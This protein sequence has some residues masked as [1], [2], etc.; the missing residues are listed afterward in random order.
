MCLSPFQSYL[1]FPKRWP[2]HRCCATPACG[3]NLHE[4]L[5]GTCILLLK[6]FTVLCLATRIELY[7]IGGDLSVSSHAA[8]MPPVASERQ[9]VFLQGL[10]LFSAQNQ[11]TLESAKPQVVSKSPVLH[12]IFWLWVSKLF[13]QGACFSMAV[14]IFTLALVSWSTCFSLRVWE[15]ESVA[16]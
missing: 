7:W 8:T 14:R 3:H 2:T 10:C 15:L 6:P 9:S 16:S 1:W 5:P 12:G 13:E 11:C 4:S